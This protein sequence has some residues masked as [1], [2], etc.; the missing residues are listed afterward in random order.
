MYCNYCLQPIPDRSSRCPECG[1]RLTEPAGESPSQRDE[2]ALPGPRMLAVA[3]LVAI[4]LPV[5]ACGV[6]GLMRPSL[7]PASMVALLARDTPPA[8]ATPQVTRAVFATPP[9]LS[10]KEH[11]NRQLNFTISFPASWSVLNQAQ[12][13]WQRFAQEEA[14]RYAWA[15]DVYQVDETPVDPRTRAVDVDTFNLNQGRV[16]IFNITAT[17]SLGE[18]LTL[19]QAEE[20]ARTEP[21]LVAALAGPQVTTAVT[22]QRIERTRI[23]GREA[24]M[25]EY[26]TDSELLERR[27]RGRMRIYFVDTDTGLLAIAYFADEQ[28]AATNRVL[29]EQV[30]QTFRVNE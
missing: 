24:L 5:F 20:L 29:Y 21:Q 10:W 16:A 6:V 27:L 1:S 2:L 14:K 11:T 28:L 8:P 30:V 23:D 9:P 22:S 3:A 15:D 13:G 25:I 12:R 19:A 7:L 26:T 4:L 18:G 17:G